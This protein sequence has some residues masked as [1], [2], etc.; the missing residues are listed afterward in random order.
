MPPPPAFS[1]SSEC[2]LNDP[3]GGDHVCDGGSEEEPQGGLRLQDQ[4]CGAGLGQL[5]TLAGTGFEA[6]NGN[7]G[8]KLWRICEFILKIISCGAEN[9]DCLSE[10]TMMDQSISIHSLLQL[11]YPIV[12]SQ[13]A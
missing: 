4:R 11:M 8:V 12:S 9:D 1:A 5:P 3:A 6:G 2:S 10:P 7:A 13:R